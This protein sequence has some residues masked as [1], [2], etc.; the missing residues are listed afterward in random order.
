MINLSRRMRVPVDDDGGGRGGG[1]Y[2]HTRHCHCLAV[3][4]RHLQNG[5][6]YTRILRG[7]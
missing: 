1:S 2:R 7:A 4:H 3:G 6:E 5:Y